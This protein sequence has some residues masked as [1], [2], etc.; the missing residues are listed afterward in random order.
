MLADMRGTDR[1]A[2][3][4]YLNAATFL[5]NNDSTAVFGAIGDLVRCGAN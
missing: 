5:A 4:A 3:A 1:H 2:A